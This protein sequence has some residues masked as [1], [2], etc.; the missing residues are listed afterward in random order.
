MRRI[1]VRT[2]SLALGVGAVLVA[3]AVHAQTSTARQIS[4]VQDMA[5]VGLVF[6]QTLRYTW[7]NLT[8]TDSIALLAP[9]RIAVEVLASDGLSLA[10]ATEAAVDPG[11]SQTFDFDRAALGRPGEPESGR[12]QVHLRVTIFGSSK[13]PDLLSKEGLSTIFSDGLELIDDATG[14]TAA[15]LVAGLTR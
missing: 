13:H 6:A 10:R 5:P 4:V 8:T 1:S 11:R 12:L 15:H 3:G 14:A 7:T 2:F 9:E